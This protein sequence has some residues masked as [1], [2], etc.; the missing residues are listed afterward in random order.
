M[1]VEERKDIEVVTIPE[2][3]RISFY[4]YYPDNGWT[5]GWVQFAYGETLDSLAWFYKGVNP[6]GEFL[7]YLPTETEDNV[8]VLFENLSRAG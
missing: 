4:A 7:I 1:S 5:A 2:G 3:T 8:E 6:T